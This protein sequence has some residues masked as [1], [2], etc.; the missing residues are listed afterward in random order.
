LNGRGLPLHRRIL[1]SRS[2]LLTEAK[3]SDAIELNRK[4][5]S[6]S[7]DEKRFHEKNWKYI[8]MPTEDDPF[9]ELDEDYRDPSALRSLLLGQA[10]SIEREIEILE[11]AK[12]VTLETLQMEFKV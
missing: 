11:E 8:V 5:C 3:R 7:Q 1:L 12:T 10:R 6:P 4:L 9:L 2:P